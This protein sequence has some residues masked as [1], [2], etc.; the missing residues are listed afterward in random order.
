[1]T[2]VVSLVT[3]QILIPHFF[4]EAID[5]KFFKMYSCIPKNSIGLYTLR[6]VKFPSLIMEISLC[7]TRRQL[8]KAQWTRLWSGRAQSRGIQLQN[9]PTPEAHSG[10][11]AEEGVGRL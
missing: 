5:T 6:Y 9:I 4:P 2:P 8:E 3:V 11:T 1:V 10:N 7:N